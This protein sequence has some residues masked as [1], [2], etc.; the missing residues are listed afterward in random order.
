[1]LDQMDPFLSMFTTVGIVFL[2]IYVFT[3]VAM[4]MA[5][6]HRRSSTPLVAGIV[7]IALFA[8]YPIMLYLTSQAPPAAPEPAPG[9]APE[10]I[11]VDLPAVDGGLALAIGAGVGTIALLI[12]AG[13]WGRGVHQRNRERAAEAKAVR[14][15]LAKRRALA[16]ATIDEVKA[17]Y[18]ERMVDVLSLIELHA[19]FDSKVPQTRALEQTMMKL[20]DQRLELMEVDDLERSAD[21]LKMR[22]TVALGHAAKVGLSALPTNRL[23]AKRAAGLARKAAS[24]TFPAERAALMQRLKAILDTIGVVMPQQMQLALDAPEHL[25]LE[26]RAS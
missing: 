22:W 19:L 15:R 13:L 8:A 7:G 5:S 23:T 11:R 20:Q 18:G 2:V 21:E 16:L 26:A 17:A 4:G 6:P 14:E 3:S 9:P 25:A 10:P 1:M 24:T 12:V